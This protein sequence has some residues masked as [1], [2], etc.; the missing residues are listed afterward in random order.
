MTNVLLALRNTL[1]SGCMLGAL[2]CTPLWGQFPVPPSTPPAAQPETGKDALGRNTPRGTV[3]GFLAAARKGNMAAASQ[4]LNTPLRGPAAES[5]ARELFTVLDRRLPPRLQELSDS[6]EGSLSDL[7]A[8]QDAVGT[9]SSAQG[10]VEV[11]VERVARGKS[12]SLWFFSRETLDRIP[13]LY[14]EI[15]LKSID[16]VLPP[17]LVNTEFGG[18]ALFEWLSVL[19]GIP[20]AYFLTVL[21]NRILTPLIGSLLRHLL[22]K[23]DLPIREIVPVPVR[24]LLI[25]F[26]IYWVLLDLS[27]PLLARQFWTSTAS[28]LTIAASVWLFILLNESVEHHLRRRLV[29]RGNM[30]AASVLR[31]GRRVLDVLV[32]FIGLV[33]GLYHFGLNPTAALAGLGVGGIAVALAA[34]KTLE[35]VLGGISIIFDQV[36]QTG[37]MLQ[38]GDTLG[39]VEDIGLRS[40]RIRTRDRTLVSVPNGQVANLKLENLSARDK[41]WF[42]PRLSLRY[43]TTPAQMQSVVEGMRKFLMEHSQVE[44]GSVYVR[45]LQFGKSSLDLDVSA[46]VFA[47]DWNRFLEMQGDLLAGVREIVEATGAQMAFQQSI[48]VAG[49]ALPGLDTDLRIGKPVQCSPETDL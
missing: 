3:L 39:T 28:I 34:Q 40:T 24:L 42:H 5:L 2:V 18:I 22:K 11:L 9:I 17:F 1:R 21:L 43:D 13:A 38:I 14:E 30:A 6:P 4:F 31:L 33:F 16:N 45:F 10:N 27:L 37:D 8:D 36:V 19:L 41:F 46:Y 32:I 44:P 47:K 49:V 7:K 48:F 29:R 23:A 12:G 35:N 26:L 25:A 20:A 15:N